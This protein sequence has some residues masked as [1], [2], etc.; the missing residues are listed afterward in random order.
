LELQETVTLD[1][2]HPLAGIDLF[3]DGQII[4]VKETTA[5]DRERLMGGEE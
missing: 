2:N 3:F 4:S 1:F 5:E